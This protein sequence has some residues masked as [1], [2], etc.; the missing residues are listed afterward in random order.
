M[1]RVDDDGVRLNQRL[2]FLESVFIS[3]RSG[4]RSEE[5]RGRRVDEDCGW[6]WGMWCSGLS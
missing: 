6:W 2:A 1:R 4:E 5:V 3:G